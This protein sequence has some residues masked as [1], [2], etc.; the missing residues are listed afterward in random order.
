V[1]WWIARDRET[2][3]KS[4]EELEKLVSDLSVRLVRVEDIAEIQR[5]KAQYGR[6]TDARYDRNGVVERS[7]LESLARD[8]TDLFSAD[9]VWDG[10]KGLGISTGHAEIYQR[11]C[12]P[13]L[14]FSLHYF[15]KPEIVVDGDRAK[16]R[17]DIL[18]PC[19]TRDHRPLWM[20]GSE[21]DEYVRVDGRWLHSAMRLTVAFM[22]PHDKG[23]AKPP[24]TG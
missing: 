1:R 19:T 18:A 22:A 17:W 9:A 4:Q 23:W 16:G 12:E 6:L 3:V 2:A 21:D 11:F 10:G 20:A 13:T 7:Q 8:I 15:V 14:R 5:L 24:R